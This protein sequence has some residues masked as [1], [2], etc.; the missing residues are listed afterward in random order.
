LFATRIGCYCIKKEAIPHGIVDDLLIN[1][2][3][4]EST[5]AYASPVL[6]K[7]K[8]ISETTEI[9]ASIADDTVK[10]K[11]PLPL[12]ED[13]LDYLGGD[14]KGGEFIKYFRALDMFPGFYQVKCR[15]TKSQLIK[16]SSLYPMHFTNFY[17]YP[18][19]GSSP[20]V[21]FCD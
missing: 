1:G 21:F 15:S 17:A 3:I 10:D 14:G 18:P 12:V 16:L 2:I 11:Y 4:T 7:K 8:K 9:C 5:S 20:S 19:D 13:Q 6:Q